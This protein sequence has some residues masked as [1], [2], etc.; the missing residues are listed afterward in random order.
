VVDIAYVGNHSVKAR[1]LRNPNQFF[2]YPGFSLIFLY[3]QS[4]SSSYNALQVRMEKRFSRGFAFRSAYT[5]G[6]AID[7]RPGQGAGLPQNSFD[8]RADRG[9]ADFDQRHRWVASGSY[10]LPFGRGKNWGDWTVHA[11]ATAQSGRPFTVLMPDPTNPAARPNVTGVD[12]RPENQGPKLWIDSAAFANPAPERF[13]NLG[14]NTLVGPG[15]HNVDV[16]LVKRF[17]IGDRNLQLRAEFF[18]VLNH[19]NFGMPNNVVGQ[20]LGLISATASPERQLQF[21]AKFEF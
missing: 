18:N 11:I 10:E 16:S 17:Y 14:R 13:G 21:G 20:T 3:E 6:H 4:G 7:D 1:R 8:L 9:N 15:L 5:W 2:G 19:P 12:W